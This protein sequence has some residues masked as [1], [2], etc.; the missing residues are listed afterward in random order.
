VQLARHQ[1]LQSFC[2][3]FYELLHPGGPIARLYERRES[4]DENGTEYS[5]AGSEGDEGMGVLP[6]LYAHCR[7]AG[8]HLWEE[9]DH[10]AGAKMSTM[11]LFPGA[12][13]RRK[14]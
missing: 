10:E 8:R 13:I 2:A 5:N 6:D 12:G 1:A 4:G 7:G 3:F 9:A 11:F 14:I